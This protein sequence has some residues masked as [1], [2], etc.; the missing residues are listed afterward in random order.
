MKSYIISPKDREILRE[1]A[2]KQYDE[3]TDSERRSF[4]EILYYFPK[5][6]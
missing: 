6:P 4:Y 3:N 2:K 1:V 5:R